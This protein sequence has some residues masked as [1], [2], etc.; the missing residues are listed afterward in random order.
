MIKR[1]YA[2][3]FAGFY[4]RIITKLVQWYLASIIALTITNLL[5]KLNMH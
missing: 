1:N 3:T 4:A 5:E 2:K